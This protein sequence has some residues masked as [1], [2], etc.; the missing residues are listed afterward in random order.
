MKQ[1]EFHTVRA[2]L[3]R[4][5]RCFCG[6]LCSFSRKANDN[7]GHNMNACSVQSMNR[8]KIDFIFISASNIANRIHMDRLQPKFHI[9]R[10]FPVQLREQMNHI[11]TQAIGTGCNSKSNDTFAGNCIAV[12][13]F[14]P[15]YRCIGVS[16]CLKVGYI[17][18]LFHLRGNTLFC[19]LQLFGNRLTAA[20]GKF[21]AA[22]GRAEYTSLCANG[23]VTIRTSKSGIQRKLVHLA[24]KYSAVVL[25]ERCVHHFR[26]LP[27]M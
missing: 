12:E 21:S 19:L 10:H 23:S 1:M 6:H 14:Q 5:P 24:A 22:A 27:I 15:L 4:L 25:I 13:S 3:H 9:H 8:I 18:S 20:L 11:I 26:S 7:M 16:K 17:L 2:G